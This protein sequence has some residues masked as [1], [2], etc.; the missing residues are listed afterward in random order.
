MTLASDCFKSARDRCLNGRFYRDIMPQLPD[1]ID[2][3]CRDAYRGGIS[4]L[5]PKYEDVEITNVKVF[6]VNSLYPWVMKECPLPIGLGTFVDEEPTDSLFFVR[7]KCEFIVKNN[8]FPFLQLKNNVRFKSNQF[9]AYSNGEVELCLTSVD[10]KN[11]KNNYHIINAHDF[12]YLKFN[13]AVG[14]LSP[15]IDYWMANKIKFEEQG[16]PFM[17]Y[18]AKTFMNG[19]YGKTALRPKRLNVIPKFDVETGQTSYSEKEINEAE[20]IYI[21]YGAFVTAYAR[22]KLINTA[23]SVWDDFIYCDTDSVHCFVR[24]SY[25]FAIDSKLLGYWKDETKD[26][27]YDF[28]RYIKQKTYCH[29]NLEVIDGKKVKKVVE[30]KAAGLNNDARIDKETGEYKITIEDFKYGL[31][32]N[33]VNLKTKTVPGGA[34]LERTDWTLE[35]H[36]I[37]EES[38]LRMKEKLEGII[39]G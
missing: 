32:L 21:P 38:F 7:F 2:A 37:D 3:F 1:E 14:L 6:D 24:D 22:D 39:D 12:T 4:Y 18:I 19:F 25:P 34:I 8:K 28:A 15:H 33:G 27:A 10:Y 26:K 35:K 36:T 29:A 9:V 31:T 11:F 20:P 30:L 5:N 17:R 23:L 16:M 13:S